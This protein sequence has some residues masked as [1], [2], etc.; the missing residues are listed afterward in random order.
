MFR[1]TTADYIKLSI[2][3]PVFF[4]AAP[5]GGLAMKGRHAWQL[6]AFGVM[7]FMTING[8]LGP[9]N[10]GLTLGSIE[11]YRGHTKGY[12]F[13][14]NHAI[15]IALIIAK[16]REDPKSFRWLPPGLGVYI[17]YCGVSLLSIGNAADKNLVIMTAHKTL[18]ASV[19]L[20]AT[21]NLLRSETDFKYFLCIMTGVMG[22]ELFVCLKLK[23]IGGMYQVRGTF[24]HQNPLA[25]YSVLVAMALLAA[26]L[27]PKFKGANWVLFGFLICAVIVECTLSRGALAM[28]AAGTVG[29]ACISLAEKV[30]AR[31]ILV[32]VSMGIVGA[33]GLIL[34]IDTILSRFQDKGNQASGELREVMKDACREMVKDY[35]LGVGWNNYGLVINPPYR[36]A[37]IYYDWI[38]GRGMKVNYSLVNGLVESHY[39]LLLSEN[40]YVG[41]AAWFV[42]ILAGL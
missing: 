4:I 34:V 13:Y 20:I 6:W 22:W 41:L 14:Y 33:I 40:G 37:E 28:F 10:W 17:L 9:G 24:E 30:T 3:V 18:F 1:L 15:A 16:W 27:G 38:R 42:V 5:L 12:H 2:I 25:M 36:Y 21:F 35:P 8:L 23:Y 31:R 32:T 39:Y 11:D 7:C 19:I 29:I 26:G